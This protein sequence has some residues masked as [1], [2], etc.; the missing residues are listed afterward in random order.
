MVTAKNKEEVKTGPPSPQNNLKQREQDSASP[1]KAILNKPIL[2][3]N[4]KDHVINPSIQK[5]SDLILARNSQKTSIT[6][7][8]N[9]KDLFSKTNKTSDKPKALPTE[10]TL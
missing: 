4:S 1:L 8:N 9:L 2:D 10:K 7:G 6:N 5:I 3:G